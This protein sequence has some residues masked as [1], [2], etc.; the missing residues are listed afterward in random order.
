MPA[1]KAEPAKQE[2]SFETALARLE[3]VVKQME[4]G[5]LPLEE[6]IERYEEGIRLVKACSDKLAAA[7][8]R[9]QMIT[10]KAGGKVELADFEEPPAAQPSGKAS[11]ASLF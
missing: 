7:E 2:P 3:T 4:D 11:E 9:I 5:T 1:K 6:L 10:K 8:Q